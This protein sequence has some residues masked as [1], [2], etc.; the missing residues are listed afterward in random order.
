MIQCAPPRYL[1]DCSV[2]MQD[3]KSEKQR[4]REVQLWNVGG[5]CGAD[6]LHGTPASWPV[7]TPAPK[8]TLSPH[9]GSRAMREMCAQSGGRTGEEA[10]SEWV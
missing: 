10:V 6:L 8:R 3:M 1:S 9:A 7:V 2:C 4:S 5:M